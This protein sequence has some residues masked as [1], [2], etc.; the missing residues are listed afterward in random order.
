MYLAAVQRL[1]ADRGIN[2]SC[3][4]LAILGTYA[5]Q[6][7]PDERS[8]NTARSFPAPSEPAQ[9]RAI[10]KAIARARTQLGVDD[11]ETAV[12]LTVPEKIDAAICLLLSYAVAGIYAHVEVVTR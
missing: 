12:I 3:R 10:W 11:C 6:A 7:V 1:V 8:R 4:L 2:V 5:L 9:R